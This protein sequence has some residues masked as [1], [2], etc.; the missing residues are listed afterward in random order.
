MFFTSTAVLPFFGNFSASL[1]K[2][3]LVAFSINLLFDLEIKL[4]ILPIPSKISKFSLSGIIVIILNPVSFLLLLFFFVLKSH[5]YL[6]DHFHLFQF[7]A[8]EQER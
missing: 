4:Y 8:Y 1:I 7:V 5:I 6:F 2:D 3:F